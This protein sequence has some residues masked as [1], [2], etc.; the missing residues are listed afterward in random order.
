MFNEYPYQ[1]V[2]DLNLDYLLKRIK[3][4]EDQIK[5]IKEEIEAEIFTWVQEQLAPYEEKLN[6]LIKEVNDLSEEV[7]DTLTAYDQRITDIEDAVN[8]FIA[9]VQRQ[10][11]E[12]ANALSDLM[13]LKI[14]NNNITL[15]AEIT[16][17][18]GDLF[19]VLNPFTG[20]T[21]TIQ[22]MIDYLSSLHIN[23]GIDY[24]TMNTRALT[25]N[26]FNALSIDYTDLTL[27][28]NTLYV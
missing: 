11:I 22:Q 17:N 1:N 16:E 3:K 4:I 26:D 13:D 18:V 25:Y 27:H 20:T 8:D 5:G 23:D 10:L 15:M 7:D 14:E 9:E 24:D 2:N 6:Q 28:G 19:V 12:Q 21:V